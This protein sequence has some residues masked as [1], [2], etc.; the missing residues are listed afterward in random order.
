MVIYLLS[1]R[2][3]FASGCGEPQTARPY[4]APGRMESVP[5]ATS[6][7]L[8]S[9]SNRFAGTCIYRSIT[10]GLSCKSRDRGIIIAT[11]APAIFV[12]TALDRSRRSRGYF[13]AGYADASP[14]A[15]QINNLL[16][17]TIDT[18]RQR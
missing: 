16:P 3:R 10:V 18:D 14:I 2:A 15:G 7:Q 5:T 6:L 9:W 1:K 12:R 4:F 8:T 11:L 17:Y 13:A